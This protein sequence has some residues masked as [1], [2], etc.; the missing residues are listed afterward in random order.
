MKLVRNDYQSYIKRSSALH[1]AIINILVIAD[2]TKLVF[3]PVLLIVDLTA[4]QII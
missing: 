1:P 3:I 4:L 2:L